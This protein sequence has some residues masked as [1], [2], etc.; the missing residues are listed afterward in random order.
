MSDEF[1]VLTRDYLAERGISHRVCWAIMIGERFYYKKS[2][3]GHV[4]T[5]WSLGGAK[6]FQQAESTWEDGELAKTER[7]LTKKGRTFRR[8][9]VEVTR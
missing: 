2:K 4:M 1:S 9:M 6:L 3:Q 7:W 5:A 8:V